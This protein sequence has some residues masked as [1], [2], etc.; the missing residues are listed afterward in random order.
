MIQKN[1]DFEQLSERRGHFIGLYGFAIT[2]KCRKGQ[3]NVFLEIHRARNING[4]K[5]L[6]YGSKQRVYIPEG[7][8]KPLFGEGNGLVHR[9]IKEYKQR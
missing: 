5:S 1:N 7:F 3:K 6:D 8:W 4:K 9:Q 2:V